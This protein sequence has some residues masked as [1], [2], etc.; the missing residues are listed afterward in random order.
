MQ[1]LPFETPTQLIALALTLVA[2][3]F[4]GLASRSGGA[5][6]RARYHDEEIAHASSRQR[7]DSELRDAAQ[8]IRELEAENAALRTDAR[9]VETR[10]APLR[11]PP[12]VDPDR[13]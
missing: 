6:W 5:K 12:I 1:N 10:D 8:R 7:A 4:L 3:W 9:V 2:G 11:E 13:R